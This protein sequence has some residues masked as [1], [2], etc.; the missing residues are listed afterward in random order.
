MSK[1]SKAFVNLFCSILFPRAELICR[2][3]TAAAVAQ[4][5]SSLVPRRG[6]C[7]YYSPGHPVHLGWIDRRPDRCMPEG[8]GMGCRGKLKGGGRVARCCRGWRET[9][10]RGVELAGVKGGFS[11]W[12]RR[13]MAR[14]RGCRRSL[15]YM[16]HYATTSSSLLWIA[17]IR[18]VLP[19]LCS[20]SLSLS[21]SILF[22]ALLLSLSLE[23]HW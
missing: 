21:P 19:T 11:C 4:A 13:R 22:S 1:N 6:M 2:L 18:N 23:G 5:A 12:L 16:Y 15:L 14:A 20:L 9:R 10:H 17:N 7:S 3:S 8:S